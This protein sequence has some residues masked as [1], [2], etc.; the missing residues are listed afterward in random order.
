MKCDNSWGLDCKNSCSCKNGGNCDA[1]D[2]S[3]KCLDGYIGILY[4]EFGKSYSYDI[5][6][7]FKNHYWDVYH[8]LTGNKY[9]Y[10]KHGT[11]IRT[12]ITCKKI[13][14]Y[15]DDSACSWVIVKKA[16]I[17]WSYV[18]DFWILAGAIDWSIQI[19]FFLIAQPYF[20]SDIIKQN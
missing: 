6:C 14:C 7:F 17:F 18:K 10:L 12:G 19:S 5:A 11:I 3:C 20:L 13:P 15:K 16:K 8:I 2:G 9:I 1:V 4:Y